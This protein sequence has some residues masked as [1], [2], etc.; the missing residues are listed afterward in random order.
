[1]TINTVPNRAKILKY[2]ES[3]TFS[4]FTKVK[5]HKSGRDVN[6]FMAETMTGVID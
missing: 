3:K 1:M 2:C 4:Q 6:C 5:E